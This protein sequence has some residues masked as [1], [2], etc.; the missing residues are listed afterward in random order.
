MFD[1]VTGK[2]K[3]W[4]LLTPENPMAQK[5]TP[6]E[7]NKRLK[8]FKDLMK[9]MCIH[10]IP[11]EGLY[12]NKEHSFMLFNLRLSDAENIAKL[13]R[14]ESFFFAKTA[15][16]SSKDDSRHTSAH[17]VYY[18]TNDGAETYKPV[19]EGRDIESLKDAQD[20]FTRH[21]DFNFAV[22]MSAFGSYMPVKDMD[23]LEKSLDENRTGFSASIHRLY[24]YK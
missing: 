10:Y 3:T 2:I 6:E 16:P 9:R 5:S 8:E 22:N 15:T 20:F 18:E 23:R 21:G 19:D 14:Q 17:I 24:S 11:V 7:N 12:G 4:A 1:D 13:F